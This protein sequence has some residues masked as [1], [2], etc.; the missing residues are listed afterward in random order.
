[1]CVKERDGF[2]TS[3]GVSS[4][5]TL[6]NVSACL[7]PVVLRGGEKTHSPWWSTCCLLGTAAPGSG[8]GNYF[9]HQHQ[10]LPVPWFSPS[11]LVICTCQC[12]GISRC[13]HTGCQTEPGAVTMIPAAH[14][15]DSTVSFFLTAL[16][17]FPNWTNLLLWK[18]LCTDYE[19]PI[20]SL[21][22]NNPARGS[23]VLNRGRATQLHQL[24]WWILSSRASVK[25]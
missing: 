4:A 20:S 2:V 6:Q 1:M 3:W 13:S 15:R 19:T 22:I 23:E 14:F 25:I 11:W 5:S 12:N 18:F 21:T 17:M 24:L 8:I 16:K 9:M 7:V 10:L